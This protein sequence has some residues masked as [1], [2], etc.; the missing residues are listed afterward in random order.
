[1]FTEYDLCHHTYSLLGTFT[2]HDQ[3]EMLNL[4][5]SI[6]APNEYDRFT[7]CVLFIVRRSDKYWCGIWTDMTIEQ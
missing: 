6:M 5:N 4:A 1:M 7:S 3:L 2:I